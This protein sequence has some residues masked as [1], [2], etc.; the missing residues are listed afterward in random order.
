[1]GEITAKCTGGGREENVRRMTGV[2]VLNDEQSPFEFAKNI[3]GYLAT[4]SKIY[5]REGQRL[6][7]SILVN[8]RVR[9]VE[10]TIKGQGWDVETYGHSVH[11]EVP[12]TLFAFNLK[13]KLKLQSKIK[14]DL[15]RILHIP[16]EFITEVSL[17]LGIKDNLNWRKDSGV[18]LSTPRNVPDDASTR[19]WGGDGYFKLFLSHAS[20]YKVQTA[21]LKDR[22]RFFG[23]ACFVAHT[24][25]EPLTE[26]Q[27]E[28]ELALAS[29]D[30]L[31]ALLTPG[32]HESFWTD[33][34]VGFAF[35]RRVP[36]IPVR[37]GI[38][39]YG[40]MGKSQA[41][42]SDWKKAP[43][44]VA[45]L[46]IRHDRMFRAWVRALREIPNWDSGNLVGAVLPAIDRLSSTQIDELVA[47]Y[48]ETEELRGAFAFN[49]NQPA[50]HGEGLA[51]HLNRLGARKF[52]FDR[53]GLVQ[54]VK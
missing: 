40:F 16:T 3:D 7:Q 38:D 51:H 46:L 27:N 54:Q 52:D 24:D 4:L 17:E 28:I 36:I 32:F 43:L 53:S 29:M 37:L 6:L 48:N 9:V 41:L 45:K 1:M 11:F 5:E 12:E 34:E 22:L 31:A 23:V 20:K 10:G 47:A 2:I 49:G 14:D 8:S 25:I 26:W 44:G 15:N 30:A 18:L 21:E 33:H 50:F 35:A 19:I 39:P 42:S 13:E